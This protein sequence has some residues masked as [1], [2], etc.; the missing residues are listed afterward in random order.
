MEASE[1]RVAFDAFFGVMQAPYSMIVDERSAGDAL[2]TVRPRFVILIHPSPSF[3]RELERFKASH[4]STPLRIYYVVYNASIEQKLYEMTLNDEKAAF[5]RAIEI[6]QKLVVQTNFDDELPDG[7]AAALTAHDNTD[8]NNN[9]DS[10]VF[11]RAASSTS[12][13]VASAVGGQTSALLPRADL[14]L[15]DMREFKSALPSMLHRD[16]LR[17][18]PETLTYGDYVLSPRLCVERKSVQD[19]TSSLNNGHLYNQVVAMSRLYER[20]IL[21]IEC[22]AHESFGLAPPELLSE[23]LSGKD[24]QA[25]LA[26]L[27]LHFPK[28]RVFVTRSSHETAA[29]F[30]QLKQNEPDP[31][32]A[33]VLRDQQAVV[34]SNEAID[35]FAALPGIHVRAVAKLRERVPSLQALVGMSQEQL[36]QLIGPANAKTL[37]HFIHHFTKIKKKIP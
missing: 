8:K 22:K 1:R 11:T 20:P 26:L 5:K 19:L 34:E 6:K 35:V 24:V 15:V 9:N 25:K 27:T 13:R 28:L 32:P 23:D 37:Y 30:R 7:V 10:D 3:M 12:K 17:L 31:D 21:L 16:Q 29:L 18:R 36:T 2:S 4:R 33:A 14:V